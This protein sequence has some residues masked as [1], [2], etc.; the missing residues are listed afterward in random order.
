MQKNTLYINKGKIIATGV[1]LLVVFMLFKACSGPNLEVSVETK[2][3]KSTTR[4]GYG[5]FV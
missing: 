1:V 4:S 3:D 5:R 2:H